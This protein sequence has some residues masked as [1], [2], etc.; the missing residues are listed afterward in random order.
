MWNPVITPEIALMLKRNEINDEEALSLASAHSTIVTRQH[1]A[2]WDDALTEEE[3]DDCATE[4]ADWLTDWELDRELDR[5]L[6]RELDREL[7]F[8]AR[9]TTG[10][11]KR[12]RRQGLRTVED[13]WR[14]E[15][16]SI[17]RSICPTSCHGPCRNVVASDC[18][19]SI[20]VHALMQNDTG[21]EIITFYQG[22]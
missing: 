10:I 1:S 4:L 22:V 8:D 5:K 21:A 16:L 19:H 12:L 14:P 11:E 3:T 2:K 9:A 17:S 20:R 13:S 6:D 18:R 7:E 15:V